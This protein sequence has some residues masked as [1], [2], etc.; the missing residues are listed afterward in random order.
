[1]NLP[2]RGNVAVI[3]T[4]YN[5]GPFIGAAVHSVLKQSAAE[6]IGDIIIADDG[7]DEDTLAVLR[8][9][10]HWDPRIKVIY[11]PGGNRQ[12]AQRNM[13]VQDTD[14]PLVAFLDGDD[15][16][17]PG[18]LAAQ[19]EVCRSDPTVGLVYTAFSNF[20]NDDASNARP[21]NLVDITKAK[22]L[23]LAYF[24]N[25]PPIL[26]STVLMRRELYVKSGGMD[27]TIHCF[28]ETEFYLRV[29]PS[30]RFACLETPLVLKRNRLGSITGGRND[31]LAFH[32]FVALKAAA[33]NSD[34]LGKVPVRLAE[35]AR[36]LAN[37]HFLAG[38]AQQA[39][40]ASAFAVRLVPWKARNWLTW[41]LARLPAAA[42]SVLQRTVFASRVEVNGRDSFS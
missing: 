27:P 32:A 34:L 3:I 41:F 25:D 23:A 4:C 29:A 10:E 13:A 40:S 11:G 14:L 42:A 28:E 1:M 17:E 37:Q 38:E 21:A 18:K 6:A 39:R 12:A 33:A 20:S 8:D 24:L 16:W 15:L 19:L 35:R 26:P 7:S 2:S 5:E 36:K 9:I 22:D 31:L 30:T